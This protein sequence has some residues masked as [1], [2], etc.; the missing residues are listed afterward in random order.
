[1]L[2]VINYL[3]GETIVD[4]PLDQMLL[5]FLHSGNV[6]YR[7]NVHSV[8]DVAMLKLRFL[9]SIYTRGVLLFLLLLLLLFLLLFLDIS[10]PF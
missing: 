1:M 6:R 7:T 4:A 5:C 9:I 10:L 8:E 3:Q 2:M